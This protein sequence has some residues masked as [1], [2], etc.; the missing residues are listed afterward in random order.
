MKRQTHCL[1]LICERNLERC[2]DYTLHKYPHFPLHCS[3]LHKYIKL[4][5]NFMKRHR[6]ACS[7]R[8]THS[9]WA[10]FVTHAT[11]KLNSDP[12]LI[13]CSMSTLSYITAASVL[14]HHSL[15]SATAVWY[16]QAFVY[17][18]MKK[19]QDVIRCDLAR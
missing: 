11:L 13:F 4:F 10:L 9:A 15:L 7:E 18:R 5:L 2:P 8:Y 19:P 3:H 17:T 12:N 14:Y 1:C 16:T 6:Q